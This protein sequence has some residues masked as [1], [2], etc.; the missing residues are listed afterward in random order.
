MLKIRSPQVKALQGVPRARFERQLLAHFTKLYPFEFGFLGEVQ[1]LEIVREGIERAERRALYT[2]RQV[3]TFI[4]LT[5]ILGSAVE[6][7]PQL[8]WAASALSETPAD[9]EGLYEQTLSYLEQ[10]S[11]AD[12]K[13]LVRAVLRV[14]SYDLGSVGVSAEAEEAQADDFCDRL[15]SLY[16]E[17]FE[18]AGHEAMRRLVAQGVELAAEHGLE[19][20][21]SQF[22][23]LTLMFML[24]SGFDRDLKYPWV[25]EVLDDKT[26]SGERALRERLY[27]RSLSYLDLVVADWKSS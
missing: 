6:H 17:K 12:G 18:Y 11:G 3:A 14:R 26:L 24:G 2:Q 13:N 4:S 21:R 23:Y 16:P 1:G 8:P 27:E 10:I 15:Q 19:H 9:L 20:P 25:R 7:D 22:L 5:L